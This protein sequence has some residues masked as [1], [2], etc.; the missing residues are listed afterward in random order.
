MQPP[1]A[2]LLLSLPPSVNLLQ[3][4]QPMSEVA[5]PWACGWG[6]RSASCSVHELQAIQHHP[7]RAVSLPLLL[8]L[9]L[10]L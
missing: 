10:L 9:L 2:Q 5:A 1:T 4:Q 7:Q 6:Q 8:L 3:W